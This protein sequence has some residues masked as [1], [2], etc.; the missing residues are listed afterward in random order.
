MPMNMCF[1]FNRNLK[2]C[3]YADELLRNQSE[4]LSSKVHE[5]WLTRNTWVFDENYGDK[6]LSQSYEDLPEEELLIV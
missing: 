1:L 4:E 5:A 6:V 2:K 3:N